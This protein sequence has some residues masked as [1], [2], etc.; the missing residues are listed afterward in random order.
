MNQNNKLI[1]S[2]LTN[3]VILNILVF[4]ALLKGHLYFVFYI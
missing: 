1:N 2:I 4:D 3:F